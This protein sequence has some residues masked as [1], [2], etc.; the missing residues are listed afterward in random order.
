MIF[1]KKKTIK[2]DSIN[3]RK[4]FSETIPK[5]HRLISKT[6]D[7]VLLD[8]IQPIIVDKNYVLIDGYCSYLIRK[9]L[10]EKKVRVVI[11]DSKKFEKVK[12]DES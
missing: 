10:G 9:T 4:E 5:P 6:A 1:T 11:V 7:Y 3:V 12:A 8:K 2:L